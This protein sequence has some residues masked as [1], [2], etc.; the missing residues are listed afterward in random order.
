MGTDES[1]FTQMFVTRFPLEIA[2]IAGFYQQIAGVDLYTTLK[3][4]ISGNI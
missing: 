1:V 4:E 2:A 3:K